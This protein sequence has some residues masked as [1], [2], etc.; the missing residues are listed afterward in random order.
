MW[1][2]EIFVEPVPLLRFYQRKSKHKCSL[3]HTTYN[4][5]IQ[6]ISCVPK[7]LIFC[8]F[9]MLFL[10]NC[11]PFL[12]VMSFV[13]ACSISSVLL[14]IGLYYCLHHFL[15]SFLHSLFFFL[16]I[17][18]K[19]LTDWF[20]IFSLINKCIWGNAFIVLTSQTGFLKSG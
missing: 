11:L 6:N 18:L 10:Y 17:W 7:F 16:L 5:P 20:L 4:I 2:F 9:Y 13:C 19:H 15:P 8:N 3:I 12:F 1:H 14:K